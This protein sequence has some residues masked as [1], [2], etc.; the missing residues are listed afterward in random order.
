MERPRARD[1]HAAGPDDAFLERTDDGLVD[2][3]A[4]PEI[5]GVDQQQA[6]IGRVS[7]EAVRSASIPCGHIAAP[8]QKVLVHDRRYTVSGEPFENT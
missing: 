8:F 2:G 5:V 7:Q 1:H 3:M 6:G 4:H